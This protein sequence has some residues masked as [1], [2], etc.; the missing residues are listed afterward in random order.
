MQT[1]KC[2]AEGIRRRVRRQELQKSRAEREAGRDHEI[3]M[4]TRGEG[5]GLPAAKGGWGHD[6]KEG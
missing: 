3:D 6:W 5:G 2:V 1:Y 4:Q